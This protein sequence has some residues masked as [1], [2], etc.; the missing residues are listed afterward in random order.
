MLTGALYFGSFFSLLAFGLYTI[1]AYSVLF[2]GAF[3]SC[4]S[5]GCFSTNSAYTRFFSPWNMT[6][7]ITKYQPDNLTKWDQIWAWLGG[8]LSK[9]PHIKRNF[10]EKF[11]V[12][13]NSYLLLW[14]IFNNDRWLTLRRI[15]FFIIRHFTFFGIIWSWRFRFTRMLFKQV[16][17]LYDVLIAFSLALIHIGMAFCVTS[18]IIFLSFCSFSLLCKNPHKD[19][20]KKNIR[21][22]KDKRKNVRI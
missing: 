7:E 2:F 5:V 1:S 12:Q 17:Q 4:S 6:N 9:F 14:F 13:S 18:A 19:A 3:A 16:I 10:E 8:W 11:C 15:I 20:W 22:K 21:Q